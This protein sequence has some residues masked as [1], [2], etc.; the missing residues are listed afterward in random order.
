MD[1]EKAIAEIETITKRLNSGDAKLNEVMQD[2][3]KAKQ[4]ITQCRKYLKE[5]QSQI[6]KPT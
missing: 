2:Y 1:F 6:G 3:E 4:L 5:A